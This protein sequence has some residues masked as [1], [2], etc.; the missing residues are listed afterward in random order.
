M[1]DK[2]CQLNQHEKRHPIETLHKL[3]S[4]NSPS[5][6]K[7]RLWDWYTYVIT[8]TITISDPLAIIELKKMLTTFIETAWLLNEAGAQQAV[9][10]EDLAMEVLSHPS[11]WPRYR[12]MASDFHN[13]ISFFSD[14]FSFFEVAE[15]H[16]LLEK[17]LCYAI[18]FEAIGSESM[19]DNSLFLDFLQRL[20]DILYLIKRRAIDE[21]I[22]YKE[23][24]T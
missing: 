11:Y 18:S 13:P 16:N 4:K 17:W 23:K 21:F 5:S 24:F 9:D 19:G 8:S 22:V 1:T 15:C 3:F 2:L 14:F 20:I 7:D 10:T 12:L 6:I